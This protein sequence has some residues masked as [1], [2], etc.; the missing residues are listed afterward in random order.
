MQNELKTLQEFRKKKVEMQSE[1]DRL[2]KALG[3]VSY[4]HKVELGAMEKKFF[5][6]KVVHMCNVWVHV[7]MLYGINVGVFVFGCGLC[8]ECVYLCVLV[9]IAL[10]KLLVNKC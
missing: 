8:C 1:I 10:L 3:E 5:E 7:C 2:E 9:C 6:E 4:Q